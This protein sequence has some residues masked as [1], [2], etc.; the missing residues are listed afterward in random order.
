M[1]SWNL[2]PRSPSMTEM[3]EDYS[4]LNGQWWK[5]CSSLTAKYLFHR[6]SVTIGCKRISELSQDEFNW[7]FDLTKENMQT[8][9]VWLKKWQERGSDWCA[10]KWC[11][12]ILKLIFAIIQ[13]WF[14]FLGLEWQKEERRDEWRH[15]LVIKNYEN[16]VEAGFLVKQK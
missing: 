2:W 1:T 3:G 13:V 6:L 15:S 5:T 16:F 4:V 9:W 8:L 11:G 12:A 7:A 10:L 14:H